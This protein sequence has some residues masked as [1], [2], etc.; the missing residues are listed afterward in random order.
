[1]DLKP[2]VELALFVKN[3]TG[4]IH[5]DGAAEASSGVFFQTLNEPRTIGLELTIRH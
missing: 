4:E 2:N 1:L 5:V 3:L